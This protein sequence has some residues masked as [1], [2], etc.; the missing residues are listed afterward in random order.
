MSATFVLPLVEQAAVNFLAAQT[1]AQQDE[2]GIAL[3]SA[4]IFK[5]FQRTATV[6]EE[7][8][9]LLPCAVVSCVT[10][11][12]ETLFTGNWVAQLDIEV[13]S[14]VFDTSDA[15][16]QAMA[17]ELFAFFFSSTI[18]GS[19]TSAL[20]DFAAFMVLPVTQSRAI[21]SNCW[22]SRARFTV[23]CCGS[24]VG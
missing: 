14:K 7:K 23:R 3:D 17:E 1:F 8:K 11:T 12:A 13:R 15:A 19:L 18:A 4:R 9:L 2:D 24:T 6:D 5:G 22:V 21:E 20:S 10:A 16:H